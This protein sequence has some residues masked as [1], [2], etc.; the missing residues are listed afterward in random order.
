MVI[1]AA[2]SA[3]EALLDKSPEKLVAVVAESG[4]L[5]GMDD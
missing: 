1:F 4:P 3:F 2:R 5:V